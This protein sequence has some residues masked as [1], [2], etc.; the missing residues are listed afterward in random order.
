MQQDPEETWM[1]TKQ[2]KVGR[3]TNRKQM[4]TELHELPAQRSDVSRNFM[5]EYR[6]CCSFRLDNLESVSL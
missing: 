1:L 3:A 2:V 6:W 4:S 5:P